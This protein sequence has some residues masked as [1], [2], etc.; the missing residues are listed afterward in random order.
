M[1]ANKKVL[2]S[3]GCGC[4]LLLAVLLVVGFIIVTHVPFDKDFDRKA[5]EWTNKG[6]EFGKSTDQAGCLK[7]GLS[8]SKSASFLNIF[9]SSNNTYFVSGCLKTSRPTPNFCDGVP[10]ISN[11]AHFEW[12]K[13][14][15]R[16]NG[17]DPVKTGC[18]LVLDE[19]VNIC[20]PII[21]K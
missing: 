12:E 10:S 21:K 13:E 6:Q 16:K 8:R 20:H 1:P 9:E 4:C 19:K 5:E 14:E 18:L 7:E 11:P 2:L 3:L 17:L 15:C